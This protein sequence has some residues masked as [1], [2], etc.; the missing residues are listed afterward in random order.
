M[1]P[2]NPGVLVGLVLVFGLLTWGLLLRF[3]ST[4]PTLP[5]TAIPTTLLLAIGEAYTGWLTRAR[6]LRRPNTKPVEPLAVA[7]LAALAKATAYAG[8]AFGG[9]FAGFV[10]HVLELLDLDQPRQDAL[11]GG[12]S[13]VACVILICA[14]LFLEHCCRVPGEPSGEA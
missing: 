14:A 6:I 5:W 2:T 7:R 13:F 12:G 4:V 1:K 9:I 10:V 11:V 3:Y 8:A